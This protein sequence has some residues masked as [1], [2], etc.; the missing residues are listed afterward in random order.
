MA[1]QQRLGAVTGVTLTAADSLG[2]RERRQSGSMH[3]L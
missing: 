3:A 1:T 2:D